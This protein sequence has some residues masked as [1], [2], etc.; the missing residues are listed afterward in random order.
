MAFRR[1]ERGSGLGII[2]ATFHGPEPLRAMVPV[3]FCNDPGP[4]GVL[5]P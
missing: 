1:K 4:A 2:R 3:V 5:N